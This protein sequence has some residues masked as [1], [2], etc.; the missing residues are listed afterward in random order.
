MEGQTR[1]GFKKRM[2]NPWYR[3][4]VLKGF[5]KEIRNKY[6]LPKT[7]KLINDKDLP[8]KSENNKA[9]EIKQNQNTDIKP[10]QE[11]SLN[12]REMELLTKISGDKFSVGAFSGAIANKYMDIYIRQQEK[13]EK[14]ICPIKLVEIAIKMR[15]LV[16]DMSYQ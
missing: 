16:E 3:E 4:E 5:S 2:S 13:A 15:A 10:K 7:E 14:D 12:K 9:L 8:N 11:S 6:K 1:E